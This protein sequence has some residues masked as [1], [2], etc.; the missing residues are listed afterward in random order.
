MSLELNN[1]Q[2]VTNVDASQKFLGNLLWYSVHDL[3]VPPDDLRMALKS[4]IGEHFMPR[5]LNERDAFRRATT[6]ESKGNQHPTEVNKRV[7]LLVR[8]VSQDKET[9]IRQ[10]V[11]EVVD[12]KNT[13]LEYTPVLSLLLSGGG[14]MLAKPLVNDLFP[15][16]RSVFQQ[17]VAN[18]ADEKS[19][20]GASHIRDLVQNIIQTCA[21]VCVRQSGGVYFIPNAYDVK[22]KLLTELLAELAPHHKGQRQSKAYSIPVIDGAD[23]RDMVKDSLEDQIERETTAFCKEISERAKGEVSDKVAQGFIHRAREI[24]RIL[25]EYEKLLEVKL[26][27]A[28]ANCDLAMTAAMGLLNKV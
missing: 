14:L 7:N 10:I 11:R 23:R 3:R 8:E 16:E 22:V 17:L 26:V 9:I 5:S 15:I 25:K 1:L 18:F 21:P 28:Q 6:Y 13:R 20:Y 24:N 19:G 12:S 2:A 4:T 27:E